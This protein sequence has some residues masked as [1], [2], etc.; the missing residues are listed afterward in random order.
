MA[1]MSHQ[2]I[3]KSKII[4]AVLIALVVAAILSVTAILPAEYGLDPLGTGKAF[5]FGKLY[6]PDNG[7]GEESQMTVKKNNP[8]IKLEKAGSG[9][10]VKRP[11]EADLPAPVQQYTHREDTVR[12]TIPAG[13]GI[14]YKIRMLKYGQLKYE[15]L[16][17]KGDLYF[18]FHGEPKELKPSKNTYFDSYT[19]AYSN[20]MVG[21]F[22]SPFEGKH[23]WYFRNEEGKDIL[24]TLRLKGEYELL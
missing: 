15:W 22:L 12:V 21:T 20:N 11:A 6:V 5:G 1:E 24:V 7:M 2:I 16:T 9:P 3:E 13:K 10:D 8:V 17:S 4:K 14:E 23:G 19:I 18:D